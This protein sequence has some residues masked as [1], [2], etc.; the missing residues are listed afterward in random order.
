MN[1]DQ[2]NNITFHY[3]ISFDYKLYPL[4]GTYGGINKK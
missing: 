3:K 4:H 2:K 1:D